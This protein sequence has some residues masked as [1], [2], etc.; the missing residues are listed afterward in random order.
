MFSLWLPPAKRAYFALE[1][2]DIKQAENFAE[3][4]L[5]IDPE[6]AEV[7]LVKLLCDYKLNSIEGLKTLIKPFDDNHNYIRLKR[8]G[9]ESLC[10]PVDR[11]IK[12]IK[13]KQ[14]EIRRQQKERQEAVRKIEIYN[15]ANSLINKNNPADIIRGIEL[16][17]SIAD[18]KDSI[19]KIYFA[20]E[21]LSVVRKLQKEKEEK[22]D[23]L[24]KK[25]LIASVACF[26]VGGLLLLASILFS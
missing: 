19:E 5:N 3:Q 2:G 24:R 8:F 13:D 9:S 26:I 23:K 21:N 7:Y 25:V 4:V 6:Y 11:A 1:D 14:E 15:K 10:A 18:W 22:Q 20:K 12:I 16:F 17:E